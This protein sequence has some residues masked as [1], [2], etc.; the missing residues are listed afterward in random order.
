MPPSSLRPK[1]SEAPR[2]GQY[3]AITPARPDR[4]RCTISRSPSNCTRLTRPPAATSED[5]T[6]GIQYRRSR[7]PIG[8]PGPVSVSRSL[9]RALN[10]ARILR[11]WQG[12]MVYQKSLAPRLHPVPRSMR[13]AQIAPLAESVPPKLYGGTERVVSA[14]TEELVRRGHEVTLFASGDS[15]TQARLVSCVP[16]ALRTHSTSLNPLSGMLWE[17]NEVGRR[18]GE[19]DVIHNHIDW[20]GLAFSQAWRTPTVTTTHG[21][22]DREDEQAAFRLYGHQPFV[23]ISDSQRLPLPDLHWVRTIY[24]GI[25]LHRYRFRENAGD[26]LVFLGRM[27][28]EKGPDRA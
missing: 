8:V 28:P 4:V 17:L 7:S 16:H 27:A 1:W 15:H 5:R 19:F 24:N 9:S 22:L 10:I 14:L 6:T 3:S 11:E 26:Y 18:A 13:I 25:E 12:T 21:R 23:S 20:P 2:C